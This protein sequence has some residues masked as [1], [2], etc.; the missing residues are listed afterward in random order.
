M[1]IRAKRLAGYFLY[2]KYSFILIIMNSLSNFVPLHILGLLFLRLDELGQHLIERFG[3]YSCLRLS[4]LF[5]VVFFLLLVVFM[6]AFQLRL[7]G[8]AHDSLVINGVHVIWVTILLV[9]ELLVVIISVV[10]VLELLPVD[11][12][13]HVG[14]NSVIKVGIRSQL[15]N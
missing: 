5:Q 9:D 7:L 8:K 10:P 12:H 11:I 13:E 3:V 14:N 1:L 6:V 2:L 15:R 4:N